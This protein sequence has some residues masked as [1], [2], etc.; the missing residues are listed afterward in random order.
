[1]QAEQESQWLRAKVESVLCEQLDTAWEE[2]VQKLGVVVHELMQRFEG[3][4]SRIQ[5]EVVAAEE[6][7]IQTL[8]IEIERLRLEQELSMRNVETASTSSVVKLWT[9][10]AR[11]QQEISVEG[12]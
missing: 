12:V 8:R 7:E 6:T 4:T 11:L 2:M 1:M 5:K 10:V 9:I 3:E